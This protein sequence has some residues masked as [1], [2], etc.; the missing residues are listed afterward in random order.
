MPK[1]GTVFQSYRIY[2]RQ[3]IFQKQ[4]KRIIMNKKGDFRTIF[5]QN[6][7]VYFLYSHFPQKFFCDPTKKITE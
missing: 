4:G 5:C 1:R 6:T 2:L 3:R 7:R